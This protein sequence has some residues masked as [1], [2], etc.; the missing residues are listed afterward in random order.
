M[1]EV[2]INNL[3]GFE[4]SKKSLN[5]AVNGIIK[6]YPSVAISH[7]GI[8]HAYG[9]TL[10]LEDSELQK[11]AGD[12]YPT[13][14]WNDFSN[15][16]LAP[17]V[18]GKYGLYQR[19]DF[20]TERKPLESG[21][22]NYN[23]DSKIRDVAADFAKKYGFEIKDFMKEGVYT[24]TLSQKVMFLENPEDAVEEIVRNVLGYEKI[25]RESP[26]MQPGKRI[27]ISAF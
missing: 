26:K 27:E 21:E 25:A 12:L 20:G 22:S 3:K 11:I 14:L 1:L 2:D 4:A 5:D 6:I 13:S 19:F 23:P 16:H 7:E 15:F 8:M 17:I 18:D 9:R 24:F 10:S